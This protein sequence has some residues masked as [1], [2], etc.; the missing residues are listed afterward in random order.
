M[1]SDLGPFVIIIFRIILIKSKLFGKQT[2]FV[3]EPKLL[4]TRAKHVHIIIIATDRSICVQ[5]PSMKFVHMHLYIY[6]CVCAQCMLVY[7]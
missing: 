1:P 7:V 4:L 2:A 3:V 6:V 5:F